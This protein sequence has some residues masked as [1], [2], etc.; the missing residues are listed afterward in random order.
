[1]YTRTGKLEKNS[2]CLRMCNI[3]TYIHTYIHTNRHS[4]EYHLIF[5]IITKQIHSSSK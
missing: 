4:L 3:H 2:V 1:M 5:P